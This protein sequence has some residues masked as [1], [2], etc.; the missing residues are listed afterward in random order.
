MLISIEGIDGCGKTSVSNQL[1]KGL[2]AKGHACLF[3]N[4]NNP[5]MD[6]SYL[7]HHFS[8]IAQVLWDYPKDAPLGKLGDWHWLYLIL[9][10]YSGLYESIGASRDDFIYVIDGWVYKYLCRFEMK[11]LLFEEKVSMLESTVPKPDR[12]FYLDVSPKI[13][14]A[15]KEKI[16]ASEAGRLD[17]MTG[18]LERN[19]I[20]YQSKISMLYKARA[21]NHN[22]ATIDV[23]SSNEE[24]VASQI[25]EKVI[26]T[27]FDK[28]E[29]EC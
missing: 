11:S 15:R 22:W 14:Y 17:G 7:R 25:L 19:F 24:M 26:P 28:Q 3:L 29:L 10:W 20:D 16:K 4:K 18:D 8:T 13:A 5:Q 1:V 12:V 21:I 6:D 27:T 9:S 23:S 2:S